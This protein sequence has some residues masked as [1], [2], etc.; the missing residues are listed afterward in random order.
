MFYTGRIFGIIAALWAALVIWPVGETLAAG[1]EESA[2][3]AAR[4][5]LE[6]R[7]A[8]KNLAEGDPI[9]L[10]IFKNEA[11]L[12]V[13]LKPKSADKFIL[14]ETYHICALSGSLGP[15]TK[16]GDRQAPEGFYAV[17][18]KHFNPFSN[19]HLSFDLGYPNAYDR[20][21]GYTGNL[22]MVHGD[23]RSDGCFAMT[24]EGIEEIYTLGKGAL[25]NG[26]PFF[27]VHCFPFR[28]TPENLEAMLQNKWHEFWT[29]LEPAYRYFEEKRRPPDVI[30]EDGLYRLN[31]K[32]P[33]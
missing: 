3:A 26:Q 32:E 30:V 23:C 15:K 2:A 22:L 28:L 18:L 21:Q 5:R 33:S 24:N 9:F 27:R 10:R 31:P 11:L 12:E 20:A 8:A 19:Y 7:L 14:F 4:P 16:T 6:K 17:G 13:W 25:A 29:M 1:R